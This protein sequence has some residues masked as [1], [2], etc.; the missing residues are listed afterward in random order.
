M[1]DGYEAN[2]P[3]LGMPNPTT[4]PLTI[5]LFGTLDV[6]CHGAPLPRLRSRNGL[7]LLALLTLR[8]G[9]EV[10]RAWLA[11]TLW[12][13]TS[14]SQGLALLRR[15]LTDLRR[16]LGLEAGRIS[17][18]TPRTLRLELPPDSADV[19]AFGALIA[20][21]DAASLAQAVSLRRG[22]LLEGCSEEW[23]F[24]ERQVREEAYLGALERLAAEESARGEHGAAARYLRLAVGA[25]PLRETAQRALMQAL[26]ASGE[27]GAATQAYRDLRELLHLQ[28]NAQPA[29]E[30]SALY[31]QIRSEARTGGSRLAALSSASLYENSGSQQERAARDLSDPEPLPLA[32]RELRAASR[33]LSGRTLTFLMT[34]IEDRGAEGVGPVPGTR[35]WDEHP[36]AMRQALA[37]HEALLIGCIEA[38]EGMVLKSR[39]EGDSLFAVFGRATDAVAAAWAL[40]RALRLEE[41]PTPLP[42]EVRV[43]LHTGEGE[44]REGAYFG[45]AANRC[46][47]LR[48]IGHGGQILLTGATRELVADHLPDG[49]TLRDLGTHRLRDLQ[50]PERI[51]Q[52]LHPELPADFPPLASLDALPNNLPLQV[53]SFIG[54]EKESADVKRL[55]GGTRLL[56]LT[57]TG[58][59]GKTRLALEAAADML[60]EY[61]DG[62]WLVEL[63]PLA[64]P[65]LVA[66]TV[67]SALGVREEPGRALTQT[68]VGALKP[69]GLLL[70]LDNCEHLLTACAQLAD[71]LARACPR[72]QVLATS[73]EGL[74]IAGEQTY[75]VPSLALPESRGTVPL[76]Q[77][78][79]I[80]AVRLFTERAVLAQSSFTVTPVNAAAV[81]Q[82]CQRLD[83]IPLAIELAAA[84]VKVLPVEKI[85]ERLDDRFHLLTGG[86]RTALPRQ[87]TLRALIDWS[88]ELLSEPEQALLRRLSVFAGGWTL[89]AAEAVCGGPEGRKQ[90]A[91][92]RPDGEEGNKQKAEGSPDVSLLPTAY[93]LPPSDVLDLLT[94]LVEKS[95]VL[96]EE[97][98]GEG[99][100]RLLE[101]V[102]QYARDRLVEAGDVAALRGRHRD[103]FLGLAEE[104]EQHFLGPEE[105]AWFARLDVEHDNLRAVLDW[106]AEDAL[107]V[108]PGLR[109]VGALGHFWTM[110]SYLREEKERSDRALARQGAERRTAGRAK[111]LARAGLNALKRGDPA[112]KSLIEESL[113]LYRELDDKVGIALGL[114]MLGGLPDQQAVTRRALCEQSLAIMREHHSRP[115]HLA[116]ALVFLARA[117]RAL[118]DHTAES[119][120]LEEVLALRP[121][122]GEGDAIAQALHARALISLRQGESTEAQ[123]YVKDALCIYH[124]LRFKQ[125]VA[126][127]VQHM[128][129]I[130]LAEGQVERSARLLG[131]VQTLF[132]EYG[133]PIDQGAF[134]RNA[135]PA[136]AALGEERFAA[137]WDEGRAMSLE[138]AV[139]FALED[140]SPV[141]A[142]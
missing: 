18:P 114:A 2:S 80:E 124:R 131:V 12:P 93:C 123:R 101:T 73:R 44:F 34:D 55:L 84:R 70:L 136:R 7:W 41:W 1:E 96:Y 112:T 14:T 45:A 118:G 109:L 21:G 57:G 32:D 40:Q 11:G 47:R 111:A 142:E 92:G 132:E 65:S 69:K 9:C 81:A 94:S 25:D 86:S 23:V 87:Q 74:N 113:A 85:A 134:H 77:L 82:V 68:L 24:Q 125:G 104:A 64:D 49:V 28:L 35:L 17:A 122:L 100:Y 36:D 59:T 99:R 67:A 129:N 13:D 78:Q 121:Q 48:G 62:V 115:G 46:A 16:A 137:A 106:C 54:R 52:V 105:Q 108:E 38:H 90:K 133:T 71:T 53:T 98:G 27:Y 75:R 42:L 60:P 141:E 128:A 56:T 66:Q 76:E 22:P 4:S 61:P 138:Q 119:A 30:T 120:L 72:L 26:A 10:D 58:G 43:A 102:R 107:G 117:S 83:G 3:A 63:A 139:A 39:G 135:A 6:Q 8:H 126:W 79:E 15:E 103:F 95:L 130:A 88:W 91:E 31:Q 140:S 127:S 20:R 5:Q 33:E 37:R 116:Y 29:P 50:R 89:E 110:R 19:V 51:F 97:R